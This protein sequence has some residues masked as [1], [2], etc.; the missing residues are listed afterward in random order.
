VT[1]AVSVAIVAASLLTGAAPA[2][3]DSDKT[4]DCIQINQIKRTKIVDDQNIIFY[5][6]GNKSY[7][8]HLPNKCSGLKSEDK[9][10][11]KT[12]LSQ[13]CNV[14]I[15]TVLHQDGAGMS[16][17]AS[18]G[19]GSFQLVESPAGEAKVP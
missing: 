12:S 11:Y 10:L 16:P 1:Y 13:L 5:M 19:L 6:R 17:G 3:A 18:C 9:Y 2:T 15:I 7:N 8:N 4:L 14:D